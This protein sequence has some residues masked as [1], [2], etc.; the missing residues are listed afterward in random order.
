MSLTW[1]KPWKR[2]L[3][4]CVDTNATPAWVEQTGTQRQKGAPIAAGLVWV[5]V[6]GQWPPG[7][8]GDDD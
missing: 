4:L 5:Y 6:I 1:R 3:L 2:T 7:Q 8:G